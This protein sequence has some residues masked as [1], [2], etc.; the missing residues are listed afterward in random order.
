MLL[1]LSICLVAQPST[2][3]EDRIEMSS[4]AS[5]PFVCLR[6]SQSALAVWQASHPEWHVERWRCAAKGSVPKDL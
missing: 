4:G 3:R 5:S 1:L 2:C 6:N